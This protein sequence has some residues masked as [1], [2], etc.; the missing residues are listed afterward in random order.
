MTCA[1]PARPRSA[2]GDNRPVRARQGKVVALAAACLAAAAGVAGCATGP[3]PAISPQELAAA[4]TFPLFK[5]YWVGRRFA[6]AP[7]TA[8]GSIYGYNPHSGETVYYGNCEPRT[9]VLGEGTCKLPL[10]V[11][12]IIYTPH[13]NAPLG[14]QLNLVLRG[15][16]AVS[17][18]SGRA[19]L[20]Y[21]G[22]LEIRIKALSA[23]LAQQAVAGLRPLNAQGSPGEPLPAPTFCPSLSG[24]VPAQLAH[25]LAALPDRPCQQSHLLEAAEP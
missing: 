10:E 14:R 25:L 21:S 4:E 17:Y 13:S 1:V 16:P 9:S 5:L 24:Q 18:E 22:H 6:G 8:V 2:L 23:R 15:V 19:L 7:V 12:T 20:L 11:T 3:A